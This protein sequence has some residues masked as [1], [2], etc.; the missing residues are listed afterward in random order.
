MT[1]PLHPRRYVEAAV[2]D[3]W[4]AWAIARMLSRHCLE[5]IEDFPAHLRAPLEDATEAL[6]HAGERWAISA[7]GSAEVVLAEAPVR[8]NCR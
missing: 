6:Q 8:S 5:E 7:R 2:I 4:P 1:E 3:G